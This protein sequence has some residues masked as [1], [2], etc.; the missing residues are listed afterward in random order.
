MGREA[1]VTLG[2]DFCAFPFVSPAGF[3]ASGVLVR[4]FSMPE[5]AGRRR[6]APGGGAA[7]AAAS[8]DNGTTVPF[9]CTHPN[10]AHAERVGK[11]ARGL[12][13]L[14][15]GRR[16]S[17]PPAPPS[18]ACVASLRGARAHRCSTQPRTEPA[19]R[20]S[21]PPACHAPRGAGVASHKPRKSCRHSLAR[22]APTRSASVRYRLPAP[23]PLR[24][25]RG[26]AV[27]QL[28]PRITRP[29]HAFVRNS[30]VVVCLARPPCAELCRCRLPVPLR[31]C[32][33]C[34]CC[35]LRHPR[36]VQL[37]RRLRSAMVPTL[38]WAC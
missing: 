1:S 14:L 20:R 12:A 24:A 28:P 7:A 8:Y 34:A 16:R 33:R 6:A 13:L 31:L 26:C 15:A 4:L 23:P 29:V 18:K 38:R 17:A 25:P 5:R 27:S 10:A 21:G 30:S 35:A 19:F 9:C 32:A 3:R 22:C 2:F 11:Q 37:R 36:C